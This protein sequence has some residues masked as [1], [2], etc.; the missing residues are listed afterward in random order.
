MHSGHL[1]LK[2][3]VEGSIKYSTNHREYQLSPGKILLGFK[4]NPMCMLFEVSGLVKVCVWYFT[5]TINEIFKVLD[6]QSKTINTFFFRF[7][8]EFDSWKEYKNWMFSR[9]K[10]R[11]VVHY[12]T[13]YNTAKQLPFFGETFYSLLKV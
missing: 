2:Y 5:N 7:F 11:R 10:C 3:V 1:V 9:I 4:A 13:R 8:K 6:F 12:K